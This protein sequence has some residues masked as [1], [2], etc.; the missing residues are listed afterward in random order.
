M[1]V[2]FVQRNRDRLALLYHR[3]RV[4]WPIWYYILNREAR[5]VWQAHGRSLGGKVED[6]AATLCR[7]GI[8]V[9]H[10]R[11]LFGGAD[12]FAELQQYA[13]GLLREH[14]QQPEPKVSGKGFE[15]DFMLYLWGG[16][17]TNP[18]LELSNPF[19]RFCLGEPI[20]AV[21][22]G[23]MGLA[24]KFHGFS[25]QSTLIVSPGSPEYLSQRWHRDPD[26]KKLVK[27]FLYLTDVMD[28]GAG[29]FKYVK[30]S[31]FG[32]TWHGLFP[33]R[34]PAGFYPKPGAVET[35]VPP[36]DFVPCFGEAGTLI[37]CDTSG[38]HKGGYS[39]AKRRLMFSGAFVSQASLHP[40]NYERPSDLPASLSLLARYALTP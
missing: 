3:V 18:V 38:L 30:G 22:C 35:V 40:I 23:Y 7:E 6:L 12:P 33:Q 27:V 16:G 25:L 15:K 24:V 4:S 14:R 13:E 31:H 9:T 17:G 36:E 10:I 28:E 5:S 34:P 1:S 21:A 37:F 2:S 39:T 32:G 29:P 20:L 8:A 11:E 26:D 19:I